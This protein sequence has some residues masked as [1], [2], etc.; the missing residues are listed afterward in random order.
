MNL[1]QHCAIV[2][3]LM[4]IASI[5]KGASFDCKKASNKAERLIC[6]ERQLS[7]LDE[8]LSRSFSKVLKEFK[9]VDSVRKQQRRWLAEVRDRCETV[10]CLKTI[11][12]KRIVQLS[13]TRTFSPDVCLELPSTPTIGYCLGSQLEDERQ[14]ID[15][16]LD[17]FGI[18]KNLTAEQITTLKNKQERWRKILL[19]QCYEEADR[20]YGQGTG[21]SGAVGEC[22]LR[23]TKVRTNE[24][25]N[26][27]SLATLDDGENSSLSCTAIKKHQADGN[28]GSK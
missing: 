23:E 28:V 4:V 1:Y 14:H 10:Q 18:S 2:L 7:E 24:I 27:S 6:S 22:E 3:P 15:N 21:W 20:I 19:C 5:A 13:N 11:Y 26:L 12:E 8:T 16:M 25:S 17:V 9:N